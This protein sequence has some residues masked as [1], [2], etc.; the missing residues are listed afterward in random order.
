MKSMTFSKSK[1]DLNRFLDALHEFANGNPLPG[2][3]GDTVHH[4]DVDLAEA[5]EFE[6]IPDDSVERLETGIPLFGYFAIFNGEN[7]FD[8]IDGDEVEVPNLDDEEEVEDDEPRKPSRRRT[9]KFLQA[10]SN[11]YCDECTAFGFLV[12][13]SGDKVQIEGKVMR[14]VSGECQTEIMLEPNLMSAAM[15]RFVKSFRNR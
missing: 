1:F 2:V 9:K 4:D 7:G 10:I 11:T 14:D 5:H 3:D 13:L 15:R 6:E 12:S 8:I